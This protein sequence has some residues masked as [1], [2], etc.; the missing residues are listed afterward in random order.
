[1]TMG[2]YSDTTEHTLLGIA[3]QKSKFKKKKNQ[4]QRESFLAHPRNIGS[5]FL[6][7]AENQVS[8]DTNR[9]DMRKQ[10]AYGILSLF[11]WFLHSKVK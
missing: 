2:N 5:H 9:R 11:P 3:S 8:S 6:P 1:M 4:H 10:A 7:A